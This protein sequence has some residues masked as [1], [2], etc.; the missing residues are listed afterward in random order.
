MMASFEVIVS[1]NLRVDVRVS[2]FDVDVTIVRELPSVACDRDA[3]DRCRWP[4]APNVAPT[5]GDWARGRLIAIGLP[6]HE[7]DQ[8]GRCVVR[9]VDSAADWISRCLRM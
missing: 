1:R 4:M 2:P 9:G 5:V 7:A 8:A 3:A 6:S